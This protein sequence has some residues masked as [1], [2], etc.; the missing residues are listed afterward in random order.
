M[1]P[2]AL[3]TVPSASFTSCYTY[4]PRGP[5]TLV[6]GICRDANKRVDAAIAI[7]VDEPAISDAVAVRVDEC[8]GTVVR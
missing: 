5:L 6:D 1:R 3:F 7:K 4:T 8:A 2:I